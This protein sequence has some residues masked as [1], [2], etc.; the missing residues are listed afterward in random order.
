LVAKERK[1]DGQGR[2]IDETLIVE[3]ALKETLII[4]PHQLVVNEE[5]VIERSAL[6]SST[7]IHTEESPTVVDVV[8]EAAIHETIK[9]TE[10]KE[11]QT[12]I[13]RDIDE[14]EVH[15]I[16]QPILEQET[17]PLEVK[18]ITRAPLA[19]Q[20]VV[21]GHQ[22]I[23]PLHEISTLEV[24]DV[25]REV[26]IKPVIIEEVVHRKIIEEIQPIIYRE[27]TQPVL[28]RETV[29]VTERIVR[30]PIITH[31]TRAP[32]VHKTSVLAEAAVS[33]SST[34]AV[35]TPSH[36]YTARSEAKSAE[37][38]KESLLHKETLSEHATLKGKLHEAGEVLQH[39]TEKLK[40]EFHHTSEKLY[41]KSEQLE[42]KLKERLPQ[43]SGSQLAATLAV[44]SLPVAL[45]YF[46]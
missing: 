39:K 16:T 23:T 10:L 30:E 37:T 21:L 2:I 4:E 41:E 13:R 5:V 3:P 42:H 14:V 25:T 38:K 8:H 45:A 36:L 46:F 15:Q 22:E 28:I 20:D 35:E 9:P 40:D 12:F 24:S 1:I 7:L 17:L 33:P 18:E 29:P 34:F 11:V 32:I 26:I 19:R 27:V 44:F 6:N 31:E 43:T